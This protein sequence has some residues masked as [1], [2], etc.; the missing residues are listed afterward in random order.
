MACDDVQGGRDP[1]NSQ[2]RKK[3]RIQGYFGGISTR[4]RDFFGTGTWRSAH[5][6]S[7][8]IWDDPEKL[9]SPMKLPLC[10]PT[11]FE[12]KPGQMKLARSGFQWIR[13]AV[14]TS[15]NRVAQPFG[16]RCTFFFI[17]G[18]METLE[19]ILEWSI[20]QCCNI[21]IHLPSSNLIYLL[22]LARRNS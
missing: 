14:F 16:P 4:P 19:Y 5:P 3:L 21:Y 2:S 22:D 13:C 8:G 7:Q 20:W 6:R 18:S 1:Y 9:V 17:S 10:H 11:Y 12:T 15:K